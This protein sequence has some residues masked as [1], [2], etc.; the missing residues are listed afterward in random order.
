[1]SG[2]EH[3]D[4]TNF[5]SIAVSRNPVDLPS[6][7][8]LTHEAENGVQDAHDASNRSQEKVV[9]SEYSKCFYT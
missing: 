2:V 1:M 4:A 8:L 7:S 5:E 6:S 3:E 9:K